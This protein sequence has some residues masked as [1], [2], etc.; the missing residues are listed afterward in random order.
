MSLSASCEIGISDIVHRHNVDEALEYILRKYPDKFIEFV[1]DAPYTPTPELKIAQA[2]QHC[3]LSLH[4]ILK[5]L[6]LS[7]VEKIIQEL[8]SLPIKA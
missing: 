3:D 8:K 5:N 2:I 1:N 4:K 6:D 7:H